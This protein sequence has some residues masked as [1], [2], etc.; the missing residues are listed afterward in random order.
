MGNKFT[1]EQAREIAEIAHRICFSR[2]SDGSSID[3]LLFGMGYL[4]EK[5]ITAQEKINYV[6]RC[7]RDGIKFKDLP[8]DE[9]KEIMYDMMIKRKR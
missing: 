7:S 3:N 8:V 4:K 9:L 5:P 2:P 6:N 1:A